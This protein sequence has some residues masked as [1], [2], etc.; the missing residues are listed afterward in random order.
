MLFRSARHQRERF[1]ALVQRYLQGALDHG[2]ATA[3]PLAAF[4]DRLNRQVDRM[5]TFARDQASNEQA[6]GFNI[7][8]NE[9]TATRDALTADVQAL[10]DAVKARAKAWK[11]GAAPNNA[12]LH[13]TREAL[14][15]VA[16]R[17]RDLAR[18]IDLAAAHVYQHVWQQAL[19]GDAARAT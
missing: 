10:A 4:M 3:A 9:L 11:P 16:E 2:E 14:H 5:R 19:R 17:C 8:W 6:D 13:K 7:I 1:L 12:S 15:D 18:Q